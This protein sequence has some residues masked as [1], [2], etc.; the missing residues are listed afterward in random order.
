MQNLELKAHCPNHFVTPQELVPYHSACLQQTDTYFTVS[1]NYRL[2]LREEQ[3]HAYAILYARP[4]TQSEKVSDY[5]FYEVINPTQF[6][7]VFGPGLTK[8]VVVKKTRDLFLYK[9][10]SVRIHL[11]KVEEL[12]SFLEIEVIINEDMSPSEASEM[13]TRVIKM[14][15]IQNEHKIAS[16]YRELL[17][18]KQRTR[19]SVKKSLEYY[20]SQNKIY[21]VVNSDVKVNDE[22]LFPANDIA[23]CL[24]VE[25]QEGKYH[26]LQLDPSTRDD[27]FKYTAWRKFLGQVHNTRVN[28]LLIKSTD[29]SFILYNLAGQIVDYDDIEPPRTFV[30]KEYLAKFSI[31]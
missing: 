23:P 25:E 26:I 1:E 17:L 5:D 12:G 16:G 2:K 24:Y 19:S 30:D 10:K 22:V 21:W 4:D 20:A 8:E 7:K 14:L 29:N 31:V 28:V 27:N 15:G 6:L 9:S 11:D 18:E 3:D 13:M